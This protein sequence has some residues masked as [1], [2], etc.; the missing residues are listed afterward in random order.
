MRESWAMPKPQVLGLCLFLPMAAVGC[1]T[2][3]ALGGG[4]GFGATD[5]SNSPDRWGTDAGL[6]QEA[7]VSRPATLPGNQSR[8]D[9]AVPGHLSSAPDSVSPG[10]FLLQR[11]TRAHTILLRWRKRSQR[12]VLG[13][14]HRGRCRGRSQRDIR[15]R[16]VHE[17][18]LVSWRP[19]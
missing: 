19:V 16:L 14:R 12:R 10:T 1:G 15:A 18:I 13:R 17:S 3:Q 8:S 7:H 2:R 9:P 6:V 11:W 5:F 4:L